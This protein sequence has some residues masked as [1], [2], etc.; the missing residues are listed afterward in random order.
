[1]S[2]GFGIVTPV[3]SPML[4]RV[5]RE[6]RLG[7]DQA[8]QQRRKQL[9]RPKPEE[10]VTPDDAVDQDPIPSTHVDLRI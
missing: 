1:M 3:A 7:R 6:E 4:D 8:R 5:S 10:D 2:D 9:D